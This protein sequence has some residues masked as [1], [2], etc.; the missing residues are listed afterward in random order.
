LAPRAIAAGALLAC[1]FRGRQLATARGADSEPG[2]D[3]A[4]DGFRF[5]RDF[6][7]R[8]IL[9]RVLDVDRVEIGP[10]LACFLIP[11]EPTDR[12][13]SGYENGYD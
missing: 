5:R 3:L 2:N 10:I 6:L 7:R 1:R 12:N 13:E 4:N 8:L 9:D 11:K